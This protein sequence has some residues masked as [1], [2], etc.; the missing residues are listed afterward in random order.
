MKEEIT[1]ALVEDQAEFRRVIEMALS[2]ID[3]LRLLG[4]YG[5]S[6]KLLQKLSEKKAW[7]PDVILLD[8]NL[9][10][11]GGLEALPLIKR[12]APRS[13]VIVLT[14]SNREG[15]V[16][17]AIA[18]GASGYLLKSAT[19]DELAEGIRMVR[20]GAAALDPKMARYLLDKVNDRSGGKRKEELKLS[21]RKIEVLELIA[22]GLVKKEIAERLDIAYGTVETYVKMI[23]QELG[24]SNAPSAVSKAYQKGLLKGGENE[25][26]R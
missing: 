24:V 7:V 16:L 23:Y 9:F 5:T 2:D 4:V 21:K 18:N 8:L 11:M 12:A 22:E 10:G 15:D 14:N 17:A 25:G 6:E 3:D 26:E 19:V 20:Q 1:V 13:E